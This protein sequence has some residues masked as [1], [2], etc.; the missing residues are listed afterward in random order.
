MTGTR[1]SGLGRGLSSL[2]PTSQ[3]EEAQNLSSRQQALRNM[4]DASFELIEADHEVA[5]AAYL[6]V[7]IG[8]EPLLFLHRPAFSTLT[9]TTAFR[10][11]HQIAQLSNA[12][13]PAGAFALEDW[14]GIYL[15]S[16]GERSD[17]IHL[18]AR[19]GQP[20]ETNAVERL[21]RT[22]TA[23]ASV[24]HQV[25]TA[26][27]SSD[28]PAVRLVVEVE[29]AKT[30][31]ECSMTSLDGVLRTGRGSA[32]VAEEAVVRAV[33]DAV[34]SSLRFDA[35]ATVP[36]DAEQAVLTT[37]TE[38]DGT[39]KFGLAVGGSDHLSTAA[40]SALRALG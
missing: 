12:S 6:H 14:S 10:L 1:K 29:D 37:L 39:P 30:T 22:S 32:V 23:S 13:D 25:E 31:V 2:I 7:A 16:S 40:L 8:D 38:T 15:R 33:L 21:V 19:T 27:L 35:F 9:P 26:H 24:I 11:F 28:L 4:V 20:Y 3:S 36:I 18:F 17:G 34:G 5:L